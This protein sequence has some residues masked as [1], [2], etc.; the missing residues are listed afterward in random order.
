MKKH[1][2]LGVRVIENV[3]FLR[4]AARAI[5]D[6][7][8]RW[9]GTGYPNGLQGQDISIEGRILAVCDAF[10][11]MLTDRPYRPARTE[12][13]AIEELLRCAGSHFDPEVVKAFLTARDKGLA[14]EMPVSPFFVFAE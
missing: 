14:A 2:E 7:Q 4:P 12:T 1:P 8:E 3:S 9:D 10:D 13:E 5:L 6:H 11:A